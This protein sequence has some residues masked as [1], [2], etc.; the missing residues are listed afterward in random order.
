[1]ATH[2]LPRAVMQGNYRYAAL[3]SPPETMAWLNRLD[4]QLLD[5]PRAPTFHHFSTEAEAR[6]W[7]RS[8]VVVKSQ[9]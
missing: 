6:I 7:L 3:I 2:W 4:P 1:M 9:L 8:Q 5:W